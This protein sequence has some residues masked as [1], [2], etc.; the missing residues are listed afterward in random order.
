MVFTPGREYDISKVRCGS[1]QDGRTEGGPAMASQSSAVELT[2]IL[3]M[4]VLVGERI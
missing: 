4:K 2:T 1:K 3:T